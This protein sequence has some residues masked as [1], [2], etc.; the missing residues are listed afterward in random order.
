VSEVEELR[1]YGSAVVLAW[2][3]LGQCEDEFAP[4]YDPPACNEWRENLD[5]AITD[6]NRILNEH[7]MDR[8]ARHAQGGDQ[9]DREAT[10][11]QEAE[12]TAD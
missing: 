12:G 5:R 1:R 3:R 8:A 4:D 2:E 11:E 7:E 10:S 6:L 9:A